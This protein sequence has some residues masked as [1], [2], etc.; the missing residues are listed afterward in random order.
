VKEKPL[1]ERRKALE[2]DWFRKESASKLAALRARDEQSALAATLGLPADALVERL[3]ALGVRSDSRDALI[4]APL[5]SVAW[6]DGRL[7]EAEAVAAREAAEAA[8]LTRPSPAR[9]LFDA[10]LA[11]PPPGL[12]DAW[13]KFLAASWTR[14]ADAE[15]RRAAEELLRGRLR[16]VAVASGGFAGLGTISRDE[17]EVLVRVMRA[18]LGPPVR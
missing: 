18:F 9:A 6:A 4:Y 1:E 17:A 3:H 8:G 7:D 2:E 10:W 5:V 11:A 13:E 16:T 15:R 14:P 12:F